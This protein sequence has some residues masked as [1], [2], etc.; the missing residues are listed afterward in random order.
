MSRTSIRQRRVGRGIERVRSSAAAALALA[1]AFA[2]V[3]LA[4]HATPGTFYVDNSGDVACSNNGPGT[5]AQPFC[6]IT[7]AVNKV[8]GPGCTILVKAGTY[9]EQVTIPVS[10][11]PGDSLVIRAM[12]TVTIDGADS[13]EQPAL[14]TQFSG[15]VWLTP[16]GWSPVQVLLN[17]A[18]LLSSTDD[19]SLLQP[20]HWRYVTGQGLY[21]NVGGDNPGLQGIHVGH[22]LDGFH[23]NGKSWIAIRDFLIVAQD[24]KGIELEGGASNIEL[25]NNYVNL[26]ASSGISLL[27]CADVLIQG[28]YIVRNAFHGIELRGGSTGCQVL[29]NVSS[30][31]MDRFSAIAT[32]IYVNGS[33]DNTLENNKVF[34]NGDTG[35][36]IQ[37]GSDNCLSIQNVSFENADH[38]F[39]HLGVVGTVNIGNV[40]WKNATDGIAI[41]GSSQNTAVYNC[42]SV[43]NA[44]GTGGFD[45]LADTSSSAGMES[46][47]NLF[48]NSTAQKPIK[49]RGTQYA[50]VAAYS[51]VSGLDPHTLQADPLFFDPE[52]GLFHLMDGSPA[53]DSGTSGVAH[54]PD[55]DAQGLPRE[56]DPAVPNTGAGAVVFADRGAFE[57]RVSAVGVGEPV[58]SSGI[59]LSNAFPNPARGAVAFA[60]DLPRASRVEWG[61]FDL[62]GRKLAGGAGWRA[63]GRSLVSWS[64]P[65]GSTAGVR[66]AKFTIEGERFQRRFV[67]IR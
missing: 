21:V 44:L 36:E 3:P 46:D 64:E 35:I 39:Y 48:W 24:E 10:G 32:G 60:L 28:N 14:W 2:I 27:G 34:H 55:T 6:T 4:A 40:A 1:I 20:N 7:A 50:T 33:P 42:I 29:N 45:F 38:G 13:F 30:W 17:G 25:V 63:A 56:D 59:S 57:H 9:R 8:G 65:Q 22:R 51:A 5:E 54:W 19:P 31:N 66:F 52:N 62:S 11:A 47:Y 23:I 61:V 58:L 26:C 15:D 53:I 43:D 12:G 37:G 41:Q 67:T 16:I 18:L 49:Y